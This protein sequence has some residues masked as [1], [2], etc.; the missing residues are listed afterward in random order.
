MKRY[1]LRI[2]LS[3]CFVVL[4][5]MPVVLKRVSERHAPSGAA[6]NRDTVTARHGFCFQEVA[7]AAGI[8]FTHRAPTLDAKLAHIMPEVAA[9][10]A[11]VSI[12]DFDRDGWQDLGCR[13]V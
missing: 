5:A 10:G 1:I 4:L 12:V 2:V 9:L 13:K 8:D 11:A 6:P 7:K 3:T